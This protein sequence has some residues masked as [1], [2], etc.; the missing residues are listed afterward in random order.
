MMSKLTL[1]VDQALIDAAKAYAKAHNTS[2]SQLVARHFMELAAQPADPFFTTLHEELLRDGFQ[3]PT[4]E[5]SGAHS[6]EISRR[7]R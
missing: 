1:S 4:P 6:S 3:A 2:L 5:A 7:S